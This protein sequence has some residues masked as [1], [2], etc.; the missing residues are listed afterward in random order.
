M[1]IVGEVIDP[2][3]LL[4]VARSVLVDVIIITPFKG[5]GEPRICH[6]LLIEHPALIIVTQLSGGGAA[7]VYQSQ[8]TTLRLERPSSLHILEAIRLAHFGRS[9]T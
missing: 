1:L 6:Q 4:R 3:Q 5:N 9:F 2:L 7:H 8:R